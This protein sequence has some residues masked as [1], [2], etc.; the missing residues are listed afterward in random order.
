MPHESLI[1]ARILSH[2]R[3]L[4]NAL[5]LPL[6]LCHNMQCTYSILGSRCSEIRA[7]N[8]SKKGA[9]T[10]TPRAQMKKRSGKS[11]RH[12]IEEVCFL[13]YDCHKNA[14]FGNSSKFTC[15]SCHFGFGS[16]FSIR[17]LGNTSRKIRCLKQILANLV[18]SL[19]MN[20]SDALTRVSS[21]Y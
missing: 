17:F 19:W 16:V 8:Y 7:V 3:K 9:H 6:F 4:H 14:L 10:H 11:R 20:L 21:V 5:N 15:I 18:I 2:I 12:R 13:I 1:R